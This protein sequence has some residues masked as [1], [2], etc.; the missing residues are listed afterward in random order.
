MNYKKIMRIFAFSLGLA[1][2]ML[3]TNLYAQ[4]NGGG[5]F[6]KGH[7]T[8]QSDNY[9]MMGRGDMG[10]YEITTKQFEEVPLGSGWL[11]L[12]LAGTAYA[13]KKRKNNNKK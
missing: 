12:T 1:A 11:V 4:N 10:G 6:G 5:M 8:N 7:E 3:S 13:M 2:T 9:S